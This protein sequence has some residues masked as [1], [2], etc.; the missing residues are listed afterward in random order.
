[1]G[2]GREGNSQEVWEGVIHVNISSQCN[3]FNLQ[4]L[5]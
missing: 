3:Q 5:S 4:V 2:G 1:M